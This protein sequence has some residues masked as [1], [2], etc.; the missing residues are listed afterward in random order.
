MLGRIY[1][2]KSLYF[3]YDFL[4][5]IR[6]I[7]QLL[8]GWLICKRIVF[9]CIAF[10]L[11]LIQFSKRGDEV[12]IDWLSSSWFYSLTYCRLAGSHLYQICNYFLISNKFEIWMKV[13]GLG[14][15]TKKVIWM[16]RGE[17]FWIIHSLLYMFYPTSAVKEAFIKIFWCNRVVCN[18]ALNWKWLT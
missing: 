7:N 12:L 17:S 18:R 13:F 5:L 9:R 3:S 11:F 6:Y 16:G 14:W 8:I 2:L 10:K 4:A 15:D 1:K